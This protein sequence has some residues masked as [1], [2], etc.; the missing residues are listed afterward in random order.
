MRRFGA[1]AL[2][3]L[4]LV[5]NPAGAGVQWESA[6]TADILTNTAGGLRTGTR[7][8]DNLDLTLT[9]ESG[10]GQDALTG[11]LLVQGLYN[12]GALFSADVVGDLQV[13]SNIDAPEAWRLYQFWYEVRGSRW[14]A[15]A[16]LYDLNSEF[17][18]HGTGSLF[19]HSSHGIGADFGQTGRNGPGIFPVSALALRA[20]SAL[21][22]G[23]LRLAVLDGVPGDPGNIASNDIRLDGDDGALIVAEFDVPLGASSRAWAGRWSYTAR[24]GCAFAPG[25]CGGNNGWY[26]GSEGSLT[27]K[28]SDVGWFLRYGRA[29]P[30]FSPFVDYVGA[31]LVLRGP[32][33][34]RQLDRLGIAVASAKAG[35]PYRRSLEQAGTGTRSRETSWELTYRFVLGDHLAIQ[36]DI[37]Y[38]DNPAAVSSI[39]DALVLG[40]RIELTY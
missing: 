3:L 23:A 24:S 26:V 29:N 18:A 40:V 28:S 27:L 15:K 39:G 17:D 32:F 14:S 16:G 12:N 20:E 6:Y 7:Y 37:T 11:T 9:V 8:L 13:V 36:P 35:K 5:G 4:L 19:L 25:T 33:P 31:G 10:L 2:V 34:G 30:E 22:R 21:G 38:I 1:R